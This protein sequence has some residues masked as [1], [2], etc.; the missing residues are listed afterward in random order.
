MR[1]KK[2]LVVIA[3]FFIIFFAIIYSSKVEAAR[4]LYFKFNKD[5]E[6]RERRNFIA[7]LSFNNNN[8]RTQRGWARW[9]ANGGPEG[10][11]AYNF[12]G[13][14]DRITV[15]DSNTLS[16]NTTGQLT[17]SMWVKFMGTEFV[18][19]G[20]HKDY[21]HFLGKSNNGNNE[22]VFRQYNSSND[23]GRGNR[24]SFYLFNLNGGLGAGSYFQE[25]IIIGEWMHIVGVANGT[26]VQVWKNGV[27]KDADTY[28]GYNIRPE[29]G[30]APLNLGTSDGNSHFRGSID[31]LKIYDRALTFSEI[32][33]L[34][35]GRDVGG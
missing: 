8:G 7:D 19:E 17:I 35:E 11:G 33:G 14:D 12:D 3:F 21:I 22:Y 27:L 9:D 18:G 13:T 26:H 10:D 20:S 1:N 31:E 29:N 25:P 15:Q 32:R 4:V 30:E 23:E 28:S 6:Y 5:N 2:L 34:S 16:A 24:I